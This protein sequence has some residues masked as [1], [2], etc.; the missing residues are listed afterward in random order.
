[1]KIEL[2]GCF[3]L[4]SVIIN[5]ISV[6]LLQPINEQQLK[7]Y[8]AEAW[9]VLDE[10]GLSQE[11]IVEIVATVAQDVYVKSQPYAVV[12]YDVDKETSIQAERVVQHLRIVGLN[13]KGP[14][15]A[16]IFRKKK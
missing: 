7:N 11:S 13:V 3:C 16:G 14:K 12:A 9:A 15:P 2:R 8:R 4:E 6:L 5:G 10:V 1:M